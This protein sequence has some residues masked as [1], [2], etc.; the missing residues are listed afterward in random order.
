MTPGNIAK[1]EAAVLALV[2]ILHK[3]WGHY[4]LLQGIHKGS[5]EYPSAIS[6]HNNVLMQIWRSGFE[7]LFAAT[8]TLLDKGKDTVSISTLITLVRR[9]GTPDVKSILPD[10]ENQL[11]D[12]TGEIQ[13]FREWR[14]N[15]IAHLSQ[16]G[17][18]M[19]FY[20]K[21]KM[22]LVQVEKT[23]KKLESIVNEI[24]WH[25]TS[26]HNTVRPASANL[27]Q[28]GVFLMKSLEVT[29]LSPDIN[30]PNKTRHQYGRK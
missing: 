10:I 2:E 8:G 12:K 1:I 25:A 13:K 9:L 21:N 14:H 24:S 20:E 30:I 5:K 27:V 28:N 29:V 26:I 11:N 4:H 7:A 15:V 22:N 3:C 18:D 17:R 16:H 19:M 6:E 23:L